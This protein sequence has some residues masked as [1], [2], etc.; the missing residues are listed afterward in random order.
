MKMIKTLGMAVVVAGLMTT[1][2]Q[3]IPITGQVD[4]Q[5]TAILDD[6]VLL[7]ATTL[8]DIVG[9]KVQGTSTGDY[10]VAGN[11]GE[12]VAYLPFSFNP[13]GGLPVEPLWAFMH[14]GAVYTFDL[15]SINVDLHTANVLVLS[16][17]GVLK[18]NDLIHDATEGNW[19]LQVTTA[20]GKSTD[21][22]FIFQSSD[23]AE[24]QV[25]DGGSTMILLGSA[26]LGLFGISRKLVRT[27]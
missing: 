26:I 13:I 15:H 25:P 1:T 2:T 16:G 12:D 7:N 17:T 18:I 11:I 19:F 20:S 14:A 5:G 24:N 22:Q 6:P 9:A 10:E 3:A 27:A 4:I 23:S 21:A 8:V